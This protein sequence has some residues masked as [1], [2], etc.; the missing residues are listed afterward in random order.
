MWPA[1]CSQA[2]STA[3]PACGPALQLA[4]R[5]RVIPRP[6]FRVIP[7]VE[8]PWCWRS[9]VLSGFFSL[10]ELLDLT[11]CPRRVVLAHRDDRVSEA[12]EA[13][14][15]VVPHLVCDHAACLLPVDRDADGWC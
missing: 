1:P 12:E 7:V 11:V 13:F 15:P 10:D 3:G 4:R 5:S 8:L 2:S 9:R 6:L 14:P